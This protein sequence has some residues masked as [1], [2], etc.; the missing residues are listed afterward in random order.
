MQSRFVH[1]RVHTEFSMIDGLVRIKPLMKAVVERGMNAVAVTD[2]CNL[3]AAVKVFTTAIS[4][5][6]KPIIGSD[7][8][9]HDPENPEQLF[10]LLLLC[11]N[12]TGY[13]NLTC[14]VSKAYQ[15]GQ[16][17]GQPR[18]QTKW[19]GEFA[20]GLIALSGGR[21]GAIGKALLLGDEEAAVSLAKTYAECFP[22][23]FYLEIQRT[24]RPDEALYNERLVKLAEALS[25]PLVATNDVRFLNKDDFE[26]HEARVCIHDG[27]TL[28]DP[29]RRQEYHADQ[30]LRSADEMADLFK[31]LP[32][33]IENTVLIS[34]RCTVKL[35]LG[36]NY[37][38]SF[39]IPA[40]MTIE[41]YLSQLS[42]QGLEERLLQIFRGQ[43]PEVLAA[44]RA[45]YDQRLEVEL[46]VI[47]RMGF[48][49]Y[50]LIVADF[51]QWA[52]QNGVPVGPGRGSGAGSLVAY[53]LK[54]TD[55]DPLLY[56]LLFERFL[57]PERVSMPDFDI[58]FCMEGRDRVIEYVAQKY[59]RQSVSQIITFGTM[60]AKA[61]VRDVGRVLGHPYGFVDKIAKLIPFEI[62]ITLSKA[63][64]DEEELRR[65]YE[66]EEDVKELIDLALKLEGIT[67]NAG[68]H[69][70]GVVI[71][72]SK[73]TD[74]TAIYCEQGSTQIV[75]QF[76]K[77]D[78]EAVGLVKF[79]FLGLRTL[80]IIDWALA[81]VNHQYQRESRA[82]VDIALIP[83][84]DA[85]TFDLLKACQTTAVFQ[86]ESRGMKELIH[87]LQPDCF[88]DI[89]ALVALFRP[90][91]L[92]SG[93][94]DDF[95]DR[96][97]GRA[98]VEY[99]HPDLEAILK[100]T[101]G[102]ILY[103]EQV[104][105]IA[106]VLANYT[107]GG[108]DLLR[109]AMGKKK[110]EEMAKQRAIFI[111]GATGRGVNEDTAAHIFDL[112]EKFAGYGF[113]K[114]HSAAYALVAYQ[115]AWLKAHYPAAFMAAVMS[116]DMDNTD[117]VVTFIDEC[118]QMHLKVLP[119]SINQS[120]YPFTVTNDRCILFGLGAIKGVG[121]SAITVIVEE[122]KQG[123]PYT[124][125][126]NFCQRLDLRKVNRRVLEALIKSGA[127]DDF[128]VERAVLFVSLEKALKVAE[129]KQHNQT[130]GQTD[131]F[132]LM[133]NDEVEEDYVHFNPWA[134]LTRLEG[135]KET[136]GFYLTGH[137]VDQYA[138]EFKGVV[139]PLVQLNPSTSKKAWICGLVTGIRRILTKRGKKLTILALEDALKKLDVVVF[140]EVY[141]ALSSE[142][143]SGQMVVIEGEISHDDYSGGVKMTANQVLSIDEART[144]FARSLMVSITSDDKPLVP[145]LQSLLKANKGHCAVQIQ[146][147]N[148][149]ATATLSL[150][151][152]WQTRPSDALLKSLSDLLGEN[153]VWMNY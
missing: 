67:R 84:D 123:G 30:Y 53:A 82:A 9:C 105:Q 33:A 20:D 36:H 3:F 71:A 42:R 127:L 58:D 72:P 15:E 35:E 62:G 90:G 44:S 117:K 37:L 39:P 47:N 60:A 118:A 26:A 110:P 52:K 135:E 69:A 54:I 119:P 10:S 23:R 50:F 48:P 40:G 83:T 139:T 137:P 147:R 61:V 151:A 65:R 31:D 22:N 101:Y 153:K 95:I 108:A 17:Q 106:Q 104:M 75:S 124:G 79:D 68:K 64:E 5:G 18:V 102:V 129:K 89:I 143:Q 66:D 87:R 103:Q 138:R 126:F 132:S 148:N 134:E 4:Q 29:R 43:P 91:P 19:L 100:P 146:Y 27:F 32:Q 145:T 150:A 96:K 142:V 78:V 121:E 115:T 24:G 128:G 133:D 59:G 149:Q 16:Y 57:N 8:P 77:D 51:I 97:H 109:R 70:G 74:F 144:R 112:M 34:Q 2:Y 140:S 13:R 45:P 116:S 125:L 25:L 92:Q 93:M 86:L 98:K 14:L 11:Q 107:L 73:L 94:V 63:L 21:A 113:N 56:E 111:E 122:R 41:D 38:P 49:G 81:T 55:L 136:L 88:E 6:I 12:E 7:L 28:A 152:E 46:D 141:E 120:S 1:L 76:D 85:K 131:L 130:S 80:T 114:S 99:P